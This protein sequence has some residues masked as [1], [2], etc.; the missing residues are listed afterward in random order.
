L[1]EICLENE[2]KRKRGRFGPERAQNCYLIR[3][4]SLR[5]AEERIRE[6]R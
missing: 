1:K 6:D 4:R 2:E 3:R 5:S